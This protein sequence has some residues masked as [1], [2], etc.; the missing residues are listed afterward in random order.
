MATTE[1]SDHYKLA[2][3]EIILNALGRLG[4]S[5]EASGRNDI[6]YDGKKISGSAFKLESSHKG[7]KALHHATL[8]L[9]INMSNVPKY[10]NPNKAKLESKGISSVSA[11]VMNLTDEYPE[12]T[13]GTFCAALDHYFATYHDG[14][15]VLREIV[16]EQM[17]PDEVREE[18]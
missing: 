13:H 2:N 18:A 8:L 15:P 5:A 6:T 3:N 4:V 7:T 12:I 17:M 10:L 11:R 9:D 14:K 16:N 1:N